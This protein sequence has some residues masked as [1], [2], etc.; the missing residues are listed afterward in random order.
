[1]YCQVSSF[2]GIAVVDETWPL[3]YQV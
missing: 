2:C 1:M 3:H